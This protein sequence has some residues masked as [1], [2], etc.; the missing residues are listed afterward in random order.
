MVEARVHQE[1][2]RPGETA[3]KAGKKMDRSERIKSV[4]REY[5][6]AEKAREAL[7]VALRTDPS[8][9]T[10]Q[11]LDAADLIAFQSSLLD[12]Y[13][14]RLF[15]E[16]EAAIR[17]YWHHGLQI[18]TQIKMADLVE[19]VGS[20]RR[21]PDLVRQNVHAA[22]RWRNSLVHESDLAIAPIGLPTARRS[23]GKFLGYLPDDW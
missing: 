20:R 11:G 12:T 13:S 1:E 22:R 2:S 3:V 6:V 4:E 19:S 5:F 17:D 14:V 9:L 7:E 10:I 23:F 15:A 18:K 8:F 16:F 21:I